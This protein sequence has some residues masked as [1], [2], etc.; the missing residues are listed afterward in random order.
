LLQLDSETVRDCGRLHEAVDKLP[1][2]ALEVV[3]RL[4]SDRV[5]WT[6]CMRNESQ[7]RGIDQNN[8]IVIGVTRM[9]VVSW[10]GSV[11]NAIS[12]GKVSGML[13]NRCWCRWTGF[14]PLTNPHTSGGFGKLQS[15]LS[16]DCQ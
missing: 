13:T 7:C 3:A 4:Q 2:A 1:K 16:V 14:Q 12:M 11:I 5:W 8:V 15:L 6:V 10:I 9:S